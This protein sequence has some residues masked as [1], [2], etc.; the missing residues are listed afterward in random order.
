MITD[1]SKYTEYQLAKYKKMIN[2]NTSLEDSFNELLVKFKLL[3]SLGL[4]DIGED[5]SYSIY[6]YIDDLE[7]TLKALEL[8]VIE[9]NL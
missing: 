2:D 8:R 1:T 5:L 9:E 6:L 3:K 7:D 4:D